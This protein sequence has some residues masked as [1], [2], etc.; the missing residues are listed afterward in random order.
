MSINE[1]ILKYSIQL[2]FDGS[3]GSGVIFKP[4]EESNYCYIFTARHTFEKKEKY[5]KVIFYNPLEHKDDFQIRTK[6]YNYLKIN[7]VI[8]INDEDILILE[9]KNSNYS[10][11]NNILSI[12]IFN[13]DLEQ[14]LGYVVA[15]YPKS[16]DY[17]DIDYYPSELQ[18]KES[19]NFTLNFESK[20]PLSMFNSDEVDTNVGI[21]GGG[22]FVE[23][24]DKKLYLV[25][26]EIE[27]KPRNNL[28]AINISN[29]LHIINQK[30]VDKIEIGG[31][32]LFD[33]YNLSDVK[34][35]LELLEEKLVN[36]Y[37]KDIKE[38]P[39]NII[40]D[41]SLK[42]NQGIEKRYKKVLSEMEDLARSYL[43]RGAVL[44]GR[45][46]FQSTHN[47]K[48]AI[49]LNA[50]L[51]IYLAEAKYV[52]NKDT[53]RRIDSRIER[54]NQL[55]I[56]ILK[57]KIEETED[58]ETLRKLYIDLIFYFEKYEDKHSNEIIKYRKKLIALY[59]DNLL[60]I[61]AERTL[62]NREESK[63]LLRE[64]RV[65]KLIEIYFH[66]QYLSIS[67][68]TK[69]EFANKLID[70][71]G[72][73]NYGSD[74]YKLV[75]EKLRELNVFDDY[76]FDFREKLAKVDEKIEDL[77]RVQDVN[78]NKTINHITEENKNNKFLQYSIYVI[79]GTLALMNEKLIMFFIELIK[80]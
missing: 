44:N 59:I 61:E 30:V 80:S 4:F 38:D 55:H 50:T 45:D 28:K 2:S 75:R 41:N 42:I 16:L 19:D 39:L 60:F 32:S 24:H 10:F 46:N 13:D 71:L 51:E 26:I 43:Y 48:R 17:K 3:N 6:P 79:L 65:K 52:R 37:I 69:K 20:K 5:D 63:L 70:L 66:P 31:Y 8:E 57:G 56:D 72:E 74:N 77:N 36:N 64:Y 78:R 18:Y 40:R 14:D 25:A 54:D 67:E 7:R 73:F 22:V 23:G 53:Y 76:I 35:D 68:H 12:K 34:F 29:I 62:E 21:S 33:K 1:E 15:G 58:I 47:F 27:Y 9:I 11:W 49:K